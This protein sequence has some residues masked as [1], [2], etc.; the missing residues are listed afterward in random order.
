MKKWLSLLVVVVLVTTVVSS[1]FAAGPSADFDWK[2][3]EGTELSIILNK[4]PYSES[5]IGLLPAFEEL[6]GMKVGYEI[7]AEEE[8]FEKLRLELSTGTG[9]YDVFMTGPMLEWEY[10]AAGWMEPLEAYMADETKTDMPY[11]QEEDF[12]QALLAA[13]RWNMNVGS[14]LGEGHQWA[15]PVMVETYVIPY[16]ADLLE[17]YGLEVPKTLPEMKAVAVAMKEN[18]TDENFYGV[19]TRGLRTMATVATGYLSTMMSYSE[20]PM[21]DFQMTDDGK[22]KSVINQPSLVEATDIWVS[23]IKEAGPPGWTS[24]TW[25]DGKE[26]FAS[27]QYGMYP[28]CDFF[29]ASYE[30]PETSMVAGKVGY[31]TSAMKP[32]GE[33]ASAIWTWALAMSAAS[34]NKEAAWYLIQYATSAE[35][36]A[37]GTAEFNNFNPTRASV[38][39]DPDVVALTESWGS[40]TYR[41]AVGENLAKYARLGWTPEPEVWN[42]GDR[43][44]EALHE[45]WT[46][47]SD[48]QTALDSA[49]A[50]IEM[51]LENAGVVP[52]PLP[53]A[54]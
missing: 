50:D 53:N 37:V 4:H 14:G 48:A 7:L 6:T 42:V 47:T 46:G 22:I 17:E 24:I 35:A 31:T 26:L 28:D 41:E 23:M 32:G 8:Y 5:L 36:L 25:Y 27:G 13:N 52:G 30:N 10:V 9:Q 2:K 19:V 21:A 45:I 20:T 34:Q 1:A 44:A 16:R 38:W 12:Y 3:Y 39:D 40:G 54:D 51:M 29:A 15:I 18:N 49:A 33:P 11:Y 43:W